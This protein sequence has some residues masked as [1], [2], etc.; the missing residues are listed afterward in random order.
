MRH[1]LIP[2]KKSWGGYSLF[3]V[4]LGKLFLIRVT[5][6]ENRHLAFHSTTQ[7]SLQQIFFNVSTRSGTIKDRT[8]LILNLNPFSI[9]SYASWFA[10][11]YKFLRF[12]LNDFSSRSAKYLIF[13]KLCFIY[14]TQVMFDFGYWA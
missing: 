14:N 7:I 13:L 11:K 5:V 6:Y 10:E 3:V 2:R 9:W 1:D 12:P 4:T 8:S